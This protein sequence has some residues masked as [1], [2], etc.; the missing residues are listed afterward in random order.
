MKADSQKKKRLFL[1][2]LLMFMIK[3]SMFFL[4]IPFFLFACWNFVDLF[5]NLFL[6]LGRFFWKLELE[7]FCSVGIATGEDIKFAILLESYQTFW[8]PT[9]DPAVT[10]SS[11]NFTASSRLAHI[12]RHCFFFSCF[13]RDGGL[14]LRW[15]CSSFLPLHCGRV[16]LHFPPRQRII[17]EPIRL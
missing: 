3:L 10:P 4:L 11:I 13:G 12:Y 6:K 17:D 15:G 2:L 8:L 9:S 16:E 5:V 7:V 1:L 14:L